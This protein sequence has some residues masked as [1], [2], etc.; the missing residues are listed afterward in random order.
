MPGPMELTKTLK[1][2]ARILAA[3]EDVEKRIGR[4]V[5]SLLKEYPQDEDMI[6]YVLE[7]KRVEVVRHME[8][9]KKKEREGATHGR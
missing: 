3:K 8:K 4:L 7:G 2:H 1:E 6:S 5:S 9:R